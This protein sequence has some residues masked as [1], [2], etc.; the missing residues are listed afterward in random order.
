[1]KA[2]CTPQNSQ[3]TPI[4]P[5]GPDH[6][7]ALGRREAPQ[8]GFDPLARAAAGVAQVLRLE[9]VDAALVE[10]AIQQP[11]ARQG[12]VD[13]LVI[14]DRAGERLGLGPGVVV[15][16]RRRS[17]HPPAAVAGVE[18]RPAPALLGLRQELQHA[19]RRPAMHASLP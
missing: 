10:K 15:F 14:L 18:V 12:R 19:A 6:V 2:R 4:L 5:S 17:R 7:V 9:D 1:M 13:K 11:L 3:V 16:D 8:H